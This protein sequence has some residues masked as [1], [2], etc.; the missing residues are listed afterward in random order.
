MITSTPPPTPSTDVTIQSP[1]T[2]PLSE[3]TL[4][5]DNVQQIVKELV[6]WHLVDGSIKDDEAF[7]I[8]TGVQIMDLQDQHLIV[9]HNQNTEQFAASINK[10]PVALL[11]L[12]DLRAHELSLDQTMTWLPSDV[13]G[14]FGVYDQPGAPT[15]ASLQD[16]LFDMLN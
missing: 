15:T 4:Q 6:L 11:V 14:G 16:V 3:Q 7:N 10:L 9:N 5:Q 12:Q 8:V 1:G 13:R 2:A